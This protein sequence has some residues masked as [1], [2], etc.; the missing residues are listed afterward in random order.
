MESSSPAFV[1]IVVVEKDLG[2]R[3]FANQL[4]Q[5]SEIPCEM[6]F[7]P[8]VADARLQVSSG[9]VDL[10]ILVYDAGPGEVSAVLEEFKPT[11]VILLVEKGN[12][13]EVAALLGRGVYEY[14]I[15]DRKDQDL[16]LLPGLIRN[17]LARSHAEKS[18]R[19]SEKRF[20]D[21]YDNAPD[22]YF[23]LERD[24]T[25]RSVNQRGALQLG[26]TVG[27]LVGGHVSRV[28]HDEDWPLVHSQIQKMLRQP[29]FVFDLEFRKVT[30][31]GGV[32]NV[33]ERLTIHREGN[34]PR[35]SIRVIC[36][37]TTETI[38]AR[39]RERELRER[40]S[41]SERLESVA[42]LAGGVAHDLNNILGPL[43]GYPDLLM[44]RFSP[45]SREY[46]DLKEIQR[47]AK[48]AV[49]I[50]RDL[51]TL[52]RRGRHKLVPVQ[53]NDVIQEYIGSASCK[54][55]QAHYPDIEL[56]VDLASPL[57]LIQGAA[58]QLSKLLMN[59][60]LNAFE[61][62]HNRGL[63]LISTR[64]IHLDRP[65]L[66]FDPIPQGH[67][68]LLE[69]RDNGPGISESDREHIFEPFFTKNKAGR[70]GTGLGLAVV[71]GVV[72]DHAGV[73]D[74]VTE[75]GQGTTFSFYFPVALEQ[76]AKPVDEGEVYYRG[77]GR[78]LVVD[79]IPEQREIARRFLDR[80][81]YQV[82]T[83]ESGRKGVDAVHAAMRAGQ[84]FDLILMDM[85]MEEDFD[86]LDALKAI[87]KIRPDQK[88]LIVSGY[89]QSERVSRALECGAGDYVR[90][91]YTLKTLG[92]AMQ[93][94]LNSS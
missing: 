45:D 92:L 65:K 53:L 82:E 32:L 8:T 49:E 4:A 44:E 43:V 67:Y 22:M 73:V 13:K 64:E 11:P 5:T 6:V 18:L 27:E 74:L 16:S 10:V 66:G 59:M 88:C 38:S 36:R 77:G 79:D 40:L 19:E 48:Q 83:A 29:G 75:V 93:K 28:V 50:I 63:L 55:T 78:I 68:V 15:I 69:F 94:E 87:Q 21:L 1:R 9:T 56:Q 47:S 58:L 52:S 42:V 57:P 70:S 81:G 20:Q 14:L 41:R 24:G 26:Y 7:V 86:G 2:D 61:A 85:I 76:T 3:G 35:V 23:I 33:S 90:K 34:P 31:E 54:T 12:E 46:A 80:L 62:M 60:T 30:K 84:P 39:N 17:A 37:D 71:Y 51:L 25:I 72:K 91:P 89:A